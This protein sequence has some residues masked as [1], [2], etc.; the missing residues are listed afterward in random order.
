MVSLRSFSVLHRNTRAWLNT[1]RDLISQLRFFNCM[2]WVP[3][4]AF[5]SL[6]QSHSSS[7]ITLKGHR[8]IFTGSRYLELCWSDSVCPPLIKNPEHKRCCDEKAAWNLMKRHKGAQAGSFTQI[9][10]SQAHLTQTW[11]QESGLR[12]WR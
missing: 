9:A 2:G 4:Q 3:H 1:Y 12:W 6:P 5:H 8:S 7:P 11:A 10:L